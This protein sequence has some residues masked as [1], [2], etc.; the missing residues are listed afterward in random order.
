[1]SFQLT[2]KYRKALYA[3][4]VVVAFISALFI[5]RDRIIMEKLSRQVEVVMDYSD[6][7]QLCR[8]EGIS[9]EDAFVRFRQAGVTSM[10]FT[11]TSLDELRNRGK[12]TYVRGADIINT[13]SIAG[14]QKSDLAP[15]IP[16]SFCITG[17]TG[18][19]GKILMENI[20]MLWGADFAHRI[21]IPDGR[22][23][24]LDIIQINAPGRDTEY[25]GIGFDRRLIGEIRNMGFNIILRPENRS[26]LNSEG[27]GCLFDSMGKIPGVSAIIFG[28]VNEVAGYPL[29]LDSAVEG[30]VRTGY[31]FGDVEVPN[32]RARQKGAQYL[33]MKIPQQTVRVQSIN[34]L[35]LARLTPHDAVDKFRLGVRERNIRMIYLRPYPVGYNGKSLLE[36]NLDYVEDLRKELNSFGF[37]TGTASRF[38]RHSPP[39]ALLVLIALGGAGVFMLLLDY[40]YHDGGWVGIAVVGLTLLVSVALLMT[41]RIA[42]MQKLSALA[43]AVIFPIYAFTAHFEEMEMVST[44]DNF[45]NLLGYALGVLLKIT[46]ITL[47]GGILMAALMSS[48]TFMLSVDKFR[49][50]KALLVLP[51][52]LILLSYYLRGTNLRTTI[53][54]LMT[55]PL[56]IWQ[57]VVLGIL[58]ALGLLFI[59]R[60]GNTAPSLA[61]ESE[62]GLRVALE[63]FLWVRPRF[64]EFMVGHPGVMLTWGLSY[65]HHYA[66]VGILVFLAAVGQANICGTFAHVHTPVIISLV[67][68]LGG[69]A[70][71]AVTGA[72]GLALVWMINRRYKKS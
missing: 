6:I 70:I 51:P 33:G 60:S 44:R 23:N 37:V 61:T 5:L 57:V 49:G 30:F 68:T 11:E 18:D 1:M 25:L 36:T 43:V 32:D 13:L 71:G 21:R 59:I 40:F 62:L 64:K 52:V 4:L 3:L 42:L 9:V 19:T 22:G 10:A 39:P 16:G 54:D 41:G 53:R 66:G 56:Y 17:T 47:L 2:S 24:H 26:H 35:Y 7:E 8:R 29:Y 48:T 72:M 63:R 38:P 20:Q 15:V 27:V 55:I 14:V 45:W 50:V 65:L 34:P 46:A 69:L 58:G 67:R 12:L 31:S 28:G